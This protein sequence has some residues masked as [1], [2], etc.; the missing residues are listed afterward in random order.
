M[1]FG[2]GSDDS[3]KKMVQMQEEEA[4]QARQKEADRQARI[5]AG[6]ANI[7]AAFHGGNTYGTRSTGGTAGTAAVAPTTQ[8]VWV[9][10]GGNSNNT[11]SGHWETR[12]I[13]PGKAATAG[14]A[15]T[16]EQYV[17]GTSAGLGDEFYNKYKDA[18]TGYYQ[19][20]VAEKYQDAKDELTYRLARAGTLRSST[21]EDKTADL[22]GQY[23]RNTAKVLSDADAATADLKNRVAKEE[24]NAVNTLYA[25]ENPDVAANQATAALTNIS[26][27]KPDLSPLGEI[28]DV[29]AIGGANFLKGANNA[30]YSNQAKGMGGT[31]KY[32]ATK[33]V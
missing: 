22:S 21:A 2:G 16:T 27:E 26:A 13:S 14:T 9:D 33:V 23:D 20:Q 18:M 32:G 30:Y 17:T 7:K 12:T 31:G 11:K 4:A 3:S 29:A 6:I 5:N 25:T 28:F 10:T 19:P 1:C 24:Q 8:R 15:P